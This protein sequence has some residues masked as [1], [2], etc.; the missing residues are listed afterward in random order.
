MGQHFLVDDN[1]VRRTLE[2][3][4]LRGDENVLEVGPGIGTLTLPLCERVASVVAVERDDDLEGALAATTAGCER[5]AVV[6]ADAVVVDIAALESPFGQLDALVANLPYGV[7][8]T[9]ILRFFQ[10]MPSLSQATVMVQSEV[11]DRICAVPGTKEYGAYT[12][13]LRLLA[14]TA[15]RFQ[16]PPGCFLPPPRV[17]S[18]VIRLERDPLDEDPKLLA[19]AARMADAAFAQRRKTL[20]NSLKASL[21]LPLDAL[22][23]LLAQAG[24]DGGVRAETLEPLEYVAMAR[25]LG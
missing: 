7:A 17:E 24:V 10:L 11:A 3:A 13:K 8:A 16:V 14:R 20:R 21:S 12:V 4:A 25:A 9:V 18:A 6:R 22:D 2:L 1:V 5:L 23:A 19:A 15:G